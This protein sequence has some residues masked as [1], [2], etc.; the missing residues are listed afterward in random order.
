M[1]RDVLTTIAQ[2]SYQF[3]AMRRVLDRGDTL[4]AGFQLSAIE[5]T[6]AAMENRIRDGEAL[7]D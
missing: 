7:D 3:A 1:T 2:L 6:V 5:A 4:G